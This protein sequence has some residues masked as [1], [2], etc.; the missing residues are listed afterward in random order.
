MYTDKNSI[1]IDK[2]IND[3]KISK[4]KEKIIYYCLHCQKELDSKRKYCNSKCAQQHRHELAYKNYLEHPEQYNRG[5]YTPKSFY[6]KFLERQNGI[7]ALC[8][9]TT[10]HNGKPLRFVID[11]I[12][13]DA[14]NNHP[15]N[16]RLICPNCDSQTDTFKS[17]NKNS[18]RRNYYREKILRQSNNVH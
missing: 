5:N 11:H 13:G 7:C 12:D 8:P 9:S 14:S 16:I 18:K 15:N 2:K 4:P 17:K 3:K 10:E 6:D 1:T